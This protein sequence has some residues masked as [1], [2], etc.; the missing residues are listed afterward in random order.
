M[1]E[2]PKTQQVSLLLKKKN[3]R[4]ASREKMQNHTRVFFFS[5]KIPL[6]RKAHN[7]GGK[8]HHKRDLSSNKQTNKQ[9]HKQRED[10]QKREENK[11]RENHGLLSLLLFA[12]GAFLFEG[13]KVV[14]WKKEEEEQKKH[15]SSSVDKDFSGCIIIRAFKQHERGGRFRGRVF[16]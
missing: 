9:Q 14:R 6:Q 15:Q 2:T 11:T 1:K 4:E 3:R 8:L 5:F 10:G 16:R 12:F 13:V 7:G